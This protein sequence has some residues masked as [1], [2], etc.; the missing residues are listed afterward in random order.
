MMSSFTSNSKYLC[1]TA[2]STSCLGQG[3]G[4]SVIFSSTNRGC[5][6]DLQGQGYR[7]FAAHSSINNRGFVFD[8]LGQ[9]YRDSAM[10]FSTSRGYGFDPLG[11]QGY[12]GSAM[13]FSTN[14]Q[15][16]GFDPLEQGYRDSA[17]HSSMNSWK[18][19]CGFDRLGRQDYDHNY[20]VRSFI[21]MLEDGGD[22]D[23]LNYKVYIYRGKEGS[24]CCGQH[25]SLLLRPEGSTSGYKRLHIVTPDGKTLEP[26]MDHREE[27]GNATLCGTIKRTNLVAILKAADSIVKDMGK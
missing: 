11:G 18:Q 24:C 16:Y 25:W 26:R 9:D 3:Y 6:F 19:G 7:D 12:R 8:C 13:H 22:E 17:M 1:G 27:R 4:E 10:H 20:T 15:G 23:S 2:S 14:S 5:G 21:S